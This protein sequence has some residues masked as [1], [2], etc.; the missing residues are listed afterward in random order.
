MKIN[1]LALTLTLTTVSMTLFQSCRR[2]MPHPPDN[3]PVDSSQIVDLKKGLLLYL[4]FS[5]NFADS[6]GN[7]NPTVSVGGAQ[8]TSGPNG[9]S[10]FGGTGNGERVIV[11]NNGSI[12]FDSS[13]T[14]SLNV[15]LNSYQRSSFMDM[16][17]ASS[18][19]GWVFGVG[20]DIGSTNIVNMNTVDANGNCSTT[21]QPN[22]SQLLHSR[23][24]L[25]P[26][27]WYNLVLVFNRGVSRIYINGQLDST[28]TTNNKF[29]PE[30]MSSNIT[31]G[32][33]WDGDPT[34]INGK[35]DEVRLYNRALN[36]N[37][38]S[39]L[40]EGFPIVSSPPTT[41]VGLNKGLLVYLPFN[42]SIADSSG[43]NNPVEIAG[44]G[45]GL[46]YDMH[47]Y[48]NAAYGS[49]GTSGR[50]FV[51]NNGSIR[52]DTAFS[53]SMSVMERENTTRQVWASMVDVVT[54]KGPSFG[55]GNSIPGA[56]NVWLGVPW[57]T[58]TCND[59]GEGQSTN[60]TS[61]FIPQ[62][63]SW[64]NVT[65]T[66]NKGTLRIYVNGKQVSQAWRNDPHAF[67]CPGA[68]LVV[69]GWW[70]SD[71]SSINGKIDNFR[72]YDRELATDEIAQLAQYY[73]PTTNA[74][75]PVV[76]H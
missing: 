15:L 10:A 47:G 13:Y 71:I 8:L 9:G 16:V 29:V 24:T 51:T 33:W 72:L 1:F 53:I 55:F 41:G 22:N 62:P 50:I 34:S 36:T 56:T 57:S 61:L 2:D 46:T 3:P 25:Q 67:L 39:K 43:N 42:G 75:R 45:A 14:V 40:S 66:F 74:V 5:G 35:L 6:S 38:I 49:D 27:T 32:G 60:D 12:K 4:P 17:K 65:A 28:L 21:V 69:G 19:N 70:N 73:Q 18:G 44:Y 64:Y 52:F 31:V 59:W 58:I 23:S 26:N 7:N 63:E 48:A 54:G 37:E 68:K 11:T 20:T 76:Q 30:C